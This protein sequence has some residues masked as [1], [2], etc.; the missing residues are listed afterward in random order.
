[1]N[2]SE[3]E[4]TELVSVIPL[5]KLGFDRN[6]KVTATMAVPKFDIKLTHPEDAYRT[7]ESR[8]IVINN[9][10]NLDERVIARNQVKHIPKR[11]NG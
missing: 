6:D 5:S 8:S 11:L 7:R 10:T 1:M 4:I 9:I 2:I 3:C